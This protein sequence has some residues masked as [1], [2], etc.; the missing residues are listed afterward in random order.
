MAISVEKL[1]L[2]ALETNTYIITET[3]SGVSAV[4]DPATDDQRLFKALENKNVEYIFLTHGHFDHILGAKSVKEKTGAKVVIHENDAPFLNSETLS[5][6]YLHYADSMPKVNADVLTVGGMTIRFGNEI[7]KIMHT[8]GHTKG[9]TCYIFEDSRII[10]SG[11]TLFNMS[12]GRT[13]FPGGSAREELM[14]LSDLAKLHGDY[15][16]Y[17]GH[18][19]DTTLDFER[20]NNR[21]VRI[22]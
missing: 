12:A 14:S 15:K 22:R 1:V 3:E 17:C 16:V 5:L 9:G 10:F 18:G 20:K 13:D 19:P 2:G 6:Y 21:Y 4:V 7:V 11:D 8:P